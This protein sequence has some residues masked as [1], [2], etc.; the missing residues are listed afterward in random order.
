MV[1]AHNETDFCNGGMLDLL[2]SVCE[3]SKYHKR[4]IVKTGQV[5]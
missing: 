2:S 3:A 1:E 5:W 4:W